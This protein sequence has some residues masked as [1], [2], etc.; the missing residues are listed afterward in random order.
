MPFRITSEQIASLEYDLDAEIAKYQ[1]AREAH[2]MTEGIPA[3]TAPQIVETIV[4]KFN[5]EYEI[6]SLIP[7][8]RVIDNKVMDIR[9]LPDKPIDPEW[10]R[11]QPGMRIG[12][13]WDAETEVWRKADEGKGAT[14]LQVQQNEERV[15]GLI[16][17]VKKMRTDIDFTRQML[18]ALQQENEDIRKRMNELSVLLG[19]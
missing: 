17:M 10:V 19:S 6:V 3:P 18:E 15:L 11:A 4:K 9:R 2:K 8:A 16:P 13:V 12:Y 5:G 14:A 1:T 7:Y